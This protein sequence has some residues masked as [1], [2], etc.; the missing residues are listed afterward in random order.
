MQEI[1]ITDC[2]FILFLSIFQYGNMHQYVFLCIQ[3]R[4]I[5]NKEYTFKE[6]IRKTHSHSDQRK[7]FCCIQ[8]PFD[9]SYIEID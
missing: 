8:D 6:N 2:V 3:R 9:V 1:E 4:T 7:L 5:K